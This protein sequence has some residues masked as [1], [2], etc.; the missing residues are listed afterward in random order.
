MGED[1]RIANT[2][3]NIDE[4]I[5]L[6]LEAGSTPVGEKS[7]VDTPGGCLSATDAGTNKDV[8]KPP[9]A[10]IEKTI[11]AAEL[12][13]TPIKQVIVYEKLISQRDNEILTLQKAITEL[14]EKLLVK[15]GENQCAA[16]CSKELE[17]KKAELEFMHNENDRIRSEMAEENKMLKNM[18]SQICLEHDA[19]VKENFEDQQ[20]I[21]GE[22][23][24]IE[25]QLVCEKG[26]NLVLSEKLHNAVQLADRTMVAY[27]SQKDLADAR[28]E[29][30]VN[31][32]N[33]MESMH[34]SSSHSLSAKLHS[35]GVMTSN[36]DLST[37][38]NENQN[39]VAR[40]K[41]VE[42]TEHYE[43]KIR[44]MGED[45]E[46]LKTKLV[47]LNEELYGKTME[48]NDVR[49]KF[50]MAY[51]QVKEYETRLDSLSNVKTGTANEVG[52]DDG[53]GIKVSCEFI[54]N[55][56][57][58]GA[59]FN[60]ILLWMSVLRRMCPENK[61]KAEAATKFT[62]EE[63]TDAKDSLW[64]TCGESIIKKKINRQGASKTASEVNDICVALN[65]LAEKDRLP[66]F[67][68]S[69]DMI[70]RTPLCEPKSK[71]D[72]SEVTARLY[73]I[74]KSLATVQ[75]QTKGSHRVQE[76]A[77]ALLNIEKSLAAVQEKIEGKDKENVCAC[78]GEASSN[79]SVYPLLT[80]IPPLTTQRQDGDESARNVQ[81]HTDSEA[82]DSQGDN[83]GWKTVGQKKTKKDWR[84]EMNILHG[85]G[86]DETGGSLSADIDL[87]AYG[88]RK[89]TTGV[90]M[91]QYL[92]N[93]GL[94][95]KSCDLLTKYSGARTLAYKITIKR[96]DLEKAS[97]SNIWPNGVGV[98]KFKYFHNQKGQN[99]GRR[100]KS[101]FSQKWKSSM[102]TDD[103][104]RSEIW[105][106]PSNTMVEQYHRQ[107]G[108]LQQ[109][110]PTQRNLY[111]PPNRTM[112]AAVASRNGLEGQVQQP[113]DQQVRFLN[114]KETDNFYPVQTNMQPWQSVNGMNAG[115]PNPQSMAAAVVPRNDLEGQVQ[116]P[117]NQQIKILSRHERDNFNQV[118]T[119]MQPLQHG[120]VNAKSNS[121][122]Q[123]GFIRPQVAPME[124]WSVGH[125]PVVRFDDNL[126]SQHYN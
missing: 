77:G 112:A 80:Q 9:M 110:R 118:Q 107:S 11:K 100:K 106:P 61:W 124:A 14:R 79:Q 122:D 40:E 5:P 78:E 60:G 72:D 85:T 103:N 62:K 35:V 2:V 117:G 34:Q 54:E 81:I 115:G 65:T 71:N 15:E 119:N 10:S 51:L 101:N 105:N 46:T 84:N 37:M 97:N 93:K 8:S 7:G 95:I 92:M 43:E 102:V 6:K 39:M 67:L 19:S 27:N 57:K 74:E 58:N 29:I 42:I 82:I 1:V 75:E 41:L 104:K 70:Q 113:G 88:I 73:S 69:S 26:K 50:N 48:L 87:V 28:Q 86:V 25:T 120:N 30:I 16:G 17:M 108:A 91:S 20:R 99:D 89:D 24:Q 13:K 55:H 121:Q 23:K 18:N 116:Q 33:E 22:R 68:A 44:L 98:R 53:K 56:G 109:E 4:E 3:V 36:C 66:L 21:T 96:S 47:G 125:T 114:R 111:I 76:C 38:G 52:Q 32:R 45:M 12:K 126:M 63:I 59:V 31:L 83:E 64:R 123:S 90:Q 94:G 49:E